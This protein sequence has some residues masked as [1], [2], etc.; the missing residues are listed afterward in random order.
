ML[1]QKYGP[2]GTGEGCVTF[3]WAAVGVGD[4]DVDGV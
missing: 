1:K 2:N 4:G 3:C